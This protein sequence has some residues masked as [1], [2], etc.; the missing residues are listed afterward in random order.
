MNDYEVTDLFEAGEAGE[1]IQAKISLFN[2]ET[3]GS[4]GPDPAAYE[5]E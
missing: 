5:E 3:G 4:L 1:M 2:D